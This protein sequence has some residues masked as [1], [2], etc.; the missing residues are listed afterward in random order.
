MS[1]KFLFSLFKNHFLN[2]V[3]IVCIIIRVPKFWRFLC[4][5]FFLCFIQ[6][7]L[8]HHI[9]DNSVIF[10]L[11]INFFLGMGLFPWSLVGLLLAYLV[12][13]SSRTLKSS[14]ECPGPWMIQVLDSLF[15]RSTYCFRR[16]PALSPIS[17]RV[18]DKA[19]SSLLFL[20]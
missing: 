13:K 4:S 17:G 20:L 12:P 19:D 15:K 7:N 1:F 8:I 14:E 10:Y 5:P 3:Q 16:L 6:L 11:T 9:I 18:L 2:L